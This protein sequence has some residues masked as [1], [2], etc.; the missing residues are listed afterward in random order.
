[1]FPDIWDVPDG[2]RRR[3]MAT[4]NRPGP[5][6]G[7][8]DSTTFDVV[9]FLHIT[10][11]ICGFMVAAALHVALVQMRRARTI[12]ELQ[13]W[14]PIIKRLEPL[15]PVI[16]ATL[17]GLGGWLLHLSGG[18]FSWSDGWVISAIATLVVVEAIGAGVLGRR[19]T[20]LMARV[21]QEPDGPVPD[22]LRRAVL[23][24]WLWVSAHLTT[25][26][27]IG[28]VCLMATK[29]SGALSVVIVVAASAIGALS[30]IP[31]LR[32]P[33]P[34]PAPESASPQVPADH[35]ATAKA[36]QTAAG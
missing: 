27:V 3:S 33:A 9:L 31:V 29:P 14:Q 18:E 24:P 22:P 13:A 26:A 19:S 32:A 35:T 23:D 34:D 15:F 30:A 25:A 36:S 1:M 20:A 6:G 21:R 28:I 11:A 12:A 7:A 8:V 10:A 5:R 17:F 16:A 2:A 4:T